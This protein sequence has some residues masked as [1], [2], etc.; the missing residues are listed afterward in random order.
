MKLKAL[1]L[2]AGLAISTTANSAMYSI[3]DFGDITNHQAKLIEKTKGNSC[4]N[5][6][7]KM[8]DVI[9]RMNMIVDGTF[10]GFTIGLV[11]PGYFIIV[12]KNGAPQMEY[13][14]KI[15]YKH[16]TK[17]EYQKLA[18]SLVSNKY[19]RTRME[20]ESDPIAQTF[21]MTDYAWSYC[22]VNR[23]EFYKEK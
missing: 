14:N 2:I 5:K 22:G 23:D 18:M 8:E 9:L 17:E 6:V 1:S 12:S 4:L 3:D 16:M 10:E 11:P 20:M 21:I 19:D 7:L 15:L 13:T